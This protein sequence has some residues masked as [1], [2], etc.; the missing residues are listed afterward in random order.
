M[1]CILRRYMDVLFRAA[2]HGECMFEEKNGFT[3]K[4][5]QLWKEH[6]VTERPVELSSSGFYFS[7]WNKKIKIADEIL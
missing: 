5:D 3:W 7:V 4:E 6:A 2:L 1:L